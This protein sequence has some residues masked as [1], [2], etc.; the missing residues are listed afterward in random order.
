MGDRNST[1]DTI[2]VVD[3]WLIPAVSEV[4]DK[5]MADKR[6]AFGFENIFG[7][8]R[9]KGRPATQTLDEMAAAGVSHAIL[10][11][12]RDDRQEVASNALVAEWVQK[13]PERF[14]GSCCLDPREIRPAVR[15]L[16]MWVRNY[17]FR[18]VKLL[19]WA[20][21]MRPDEKM[22]YPIYAEA[23]ELGVPVTIQVGHTAPLFPSQ[24]GYPMY[25]DDVARHFPELKI[26]A[27]HLGW[28]W[29]DEVIAL[30]TK[31][32][33][34]FIDTSAHSPSRY[35]RQLIDFMS[36]PRGA[37]KVL[38]GSDYPALELER[39][40][41]SAMK[42]PLRQKELQAFLG[43]NARGLFGLDKKETVNV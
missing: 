3:V 42:L 14:T 39:L 13:W 5:W 11:A 35:P 30:T 16:R 37:T 34:V 40:V 24:V 38:F 33:N 32:P 31:F 19:P 17:G 6:Y 28:P 22:W 27:G 36:T 15:E 1:A 18:G 2:D 26:I 21:S 25:L 9:L 7:G 12:M 41:R 8:G 23:E 43:G 4:V 10:S 20:F 29:M